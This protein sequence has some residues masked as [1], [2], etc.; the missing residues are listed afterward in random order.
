MSKETGPS[1]L[2]RFII[3]SLAPE[4][5]S[6]GVVSPSPRKPTSG[7]HTPFPNVLVLISRFITRFKTHQ[8]SHNCRRTVSTKQVFLCR[9]IFTEYPAISKLRRASQSPFASYQFRFLTVKNCFFTDATSPPPKEPESLILAFPLPASLTFSSPP[10][11]FCPM[12]TQ[13][14]GILAHDESHA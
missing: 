5:R 7:P 4:L 14:P 11:I 10:Y 1:D 13:L 9:S 6:Q 8:Q 2:C 12:R 3:A